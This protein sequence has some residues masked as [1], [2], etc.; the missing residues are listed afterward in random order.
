MREIFPEFI[1]NRRLN[2][3]ILSGIII[4]VLYSLLFLLRI[5]P[6]SRVILLVILYP[7][8]IC[9]MLFPF[10]EFIRVLVKILPQGNFFNV[11]ETLTPL[12]IGVWMLIVA[13]VLTIS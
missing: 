13:V 4:A 1:K 5:F 12:I 6:V 11:I 9:F 2:I 10:T 8:A 3:I 7:A